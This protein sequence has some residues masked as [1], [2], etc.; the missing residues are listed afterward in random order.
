MRHFIPLLFLTALATAADLSAAWSG[1]LN[2]GKKGGPI[3]LNLQQTTGSITLGRL[4]TRPIRNVKLQS[5]KL[6]FE[7]A[8]PGESGLD[9]VCRY[10]L[11]VTGD[12][13]EGDGEIPNEHGARMAAKV[14][15]KR[16]KPK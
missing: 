3:A 11:T 7:V 6:T 15:L 1:T 16:D 14:S 12:A 9:T 13:M 5:Q 8:F 4:G 10:S 2:T